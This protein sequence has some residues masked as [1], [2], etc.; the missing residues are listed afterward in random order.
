MVRVNQTLSEFSLLQA[1]A[2]ISK[3]IKRNGL[4]LWNVLPLRL[5]K[6]KSLGFNTGRLAPP[7]WLWATMWLNYPHAQ[8]QRRG[9]AFLHWSNQSP[10]RLSTKELM[11]LNSGDGEDS[12]ESFGLKEIQPVN[13]KG[14]QCWMFIGRPHAEAETPILWPP[15]AKNW[16][17][18]KDSDPGKYWRQEEK[19]TTE[20]EMVGW[21]HQLNGHEL[22]Q[23]P[24]VGEGQGSLACWSPWGH[25]EKDAIEWLNWYKQ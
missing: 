13:P 2:G 24:G 12:W 19:G 10:R 16:L 25:K 9:S 21:H 5:A 1:P 14:N 15:D 22:E 8:G 17:I 6:L 4:V 7:Q 3:V 11:L 18:G 23:A 20:D